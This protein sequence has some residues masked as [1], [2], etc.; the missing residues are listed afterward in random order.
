MISSLV[1]LNSFVERKLNSTIKQMKCKDHKKLDQ[2]LISEME[3]DYK[4]SPWNKLIYILI[5]FSQNGLFVSKKN[6]SEVF[7]EIYRAFRPYVCFEIRK[8]FFE[9]VRV[10]LRFIDSFSTGWPCFYVF[11][12]GD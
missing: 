8:F 7:L 3:F 2:L 1:Q 4:F 9:K 6:Q 12:T 5:L 11:R 10:S